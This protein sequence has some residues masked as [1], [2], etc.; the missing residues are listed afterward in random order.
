MIPRSRVFVSHVGTRPR[1]LA[2][3]LLGQMARPTISVGD[4]LAA[5]P[6]ASG[7]LLALVEIRA[8]RDNEV[9]AQEQRRR[10][11]LHWVAGL[12]YAGDV[13][14]R[15]SVTLRMTANA[16]SS[17]RDAVAETEA[18]SLVLEWPTIA[19]PR[20]HGLTDLTRQLLPDRGTDIVFVRSNSPNHAITPRSIMA[21]I[22]GGPSARVVASTAAALADAYG[23]ALTLL[24]IQT[25][26]QH[27]DRSRREWESFEQIVEEMHRPS[28]MVRLHHHD[29]PAAGIL[30]EAVGHDLV[31]IGS[32]LSASSPNVL[33]GRELLR[34][35][36][37]LDCPVVMVRPKHL[38]PADSAHASAMNGNGR[39]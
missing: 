13:R 9:F 29:S 12:E 33:V 17:I 15:M 31:I 8:G 27:P 11:M 37:Q 5:S 1:V 21:S 28:T 22:R 26:S 18:T 16:A 19:S 38:T 6:G 2:P 10:D 7:N 20:R 30:E 25:D 23:S 4:A 3:V 35:V 39:R 24:H 32:R 36:R 34:M 14:R